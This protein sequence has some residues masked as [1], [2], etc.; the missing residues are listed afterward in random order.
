MSSVVPNAEDTSR[1]NGLQPGQR[2][3]GTIS[4]IELY[5]AFVDLGDGREGLLHISR[6]Q[7]D[8]VNRIED[9]L[10]VGDSLEV[11]VH[12]VDSNSGRIELTMIKPVLLKWK[13]IKP[14]MS[15][16]GKVVRLEKFGAFVDIDAERPGLIHVSE[17]S[18]EYISDPSE[19][20]KVGDEVEVHVLNVDPKKKQ[21]RL[22]MKEQIE[23]YEEEEPEEAVPTAME[24]ALKA[25]M[26]DAEPNT[27]QPTPANAV[28]SK[29]DRNKQEDILSRT[30][31]QRLQTSTDD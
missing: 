2:L 10:N 20:V 27:R 17:L 11:W 15:L 29:K 7:K 16:R 30:L 23:D 21:I 5:G 22:S 25:A 18:G 8:P 13:D 12:Q 1:I 9:L 28:K 6:I 31:A 19:V 14:G 3:E 26:E 24:I 4:K